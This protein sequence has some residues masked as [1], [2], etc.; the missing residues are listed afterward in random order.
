M[1]SA[2]DKARAHARAA[3]R[4]AAFGN[5]AKARAHWGLALEYRALAFGAPACGICGASDPPPISR[6]CAC[7]GGVAHV[8]CMVSDAKKSEAEENSVWWQCRACNQALTG[9]AQQALGRAFWN[10]VAALPKSD[11]KREVATVVWARCHLAAARYDQA[12]KY[13]REALGDS[14]LRS[15]SPMVL[16]A[17]RTLAQ[18]LSG[19]GRHA[20]AEGVARAALAAV[21]REGPYAHYAAEARAELANILGA[22]G[23]HAEAERECRK[24]IEMLRGRYGDEHP[25][26]LAHMGNLASLLMR[27][28]RPADAE[29]LYR[30]VLRA[31]RIALGPTH[32]YT[33]ASETNL[34]R[35][36]FEL[37]R[38]EEAE[39]LDRHAL[40]SA[41]EI[42]EEAPL[43]LVSANLATTLGAQKK[44]KE[45]RQLFTDALA[46][47]RR[48]Y[49][50]SH[51][52]TLAYAAQ[53]RRYLEAASAESSLVGAR[54]TLYGLTADGFNEREATVVGPSGAR[55]VVELLDSKERIGVKRE[56]LRVRCMNPSCTTMLD[57]EQSCGNC[58]SVWYCCRACQK[59]HWREHRL[60][61][62]KRAPKDEEKTTG[63]K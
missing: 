32:P 1:R 25:K 38:Y 27:Q 49:G 11:P 21:S 60:A 13:A 41:L 61:C 37:Q 10:S 33:L 6:G 51:E 2:W 55:F 52:V 36:L 43:A 34:G 46:R 59:A 31:K 58:R 5:A 29:G 35:A 18:A 16:S 40:Q 39:A 53:H 24:G 62:K 63:P 28:N 30:E 57:A 48:K 9:R 44:N 8:D 15:I 22:Q 7:I 47:L 56:N 45:A 3:R 23:K 17:H 50:A 19:Q 54:V 12:E 20:E 14:D 4:H 42:G 26:T